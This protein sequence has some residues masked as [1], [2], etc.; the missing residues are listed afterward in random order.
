MQTEEKPIEETRGK[1][2][3]KFIWNL[4]NG[5]DI[6][7]YGSKE[8]SKEIR[9]LINLEQKPQL[10]QIALWHPFAKVLNWRE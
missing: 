8:Y 3:V 9:I 7:L 1:N 10:L 6:E 5:F 4:D 2:S